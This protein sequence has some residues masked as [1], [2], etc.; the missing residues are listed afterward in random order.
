MSVDRLSVVCLATSSFSLMK[1]S[2]KTLE[3][4]NFWLDYNIVETANDTMFRPTFAVP[5]TIPDP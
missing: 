1:E 5:N 3:Q 2:H 4:T